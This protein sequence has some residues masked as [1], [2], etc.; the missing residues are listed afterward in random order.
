MLSL[1]EMALESR[2]HIYAVEQVLPDP[3]SGSAKWKPQFAGQDVQKPTKSLLHITTQR[4]LVIIRAGERS[5]H[6]IFEY[7]GSDFICDFYRGSVDGNVLVMK[8][9]A[10]SNAS[11]V[12][13]IGMSW[14]SHWLER[15]DRWCLLKFTV[16]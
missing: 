8:L 10:T 14:L 3:F 2:S 1:V 15:L 16:T 11:N 12:S 13:Q 5:I 6:A 9:V 7:Y 4:M